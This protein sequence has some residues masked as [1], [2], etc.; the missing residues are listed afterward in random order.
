MEFT[1]FR[2]E[3]IRSPQVQCTCDLSSV[4]RPTVATTPK[5]RIEIIKDLKKKAQLRRA[6]ARG[7]VPKGTV[8]QTVPAPQQ[9]AQL[10][11]KCSCEAS[12]PRKMITRQIPIVTKK[13]PIKTPY[14]LA[15]FCKNN[16]I[17]VSN[18]D[19]ANMGQIKDPTRLRPGV[20]PTKTFEIVIEPDKISQKQIEENYQAVQSY[21]PT[22]VNNGYFCSTCDPFL[23]LVCKLF[24][25][26][27]THKY[28]T[29]TMYYIN[30]QTTEGIFSNNSLKIQ[31]TKTLTFTS[32]RGHFDVLA[33]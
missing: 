3:T 26:S 32:N 24:N 28:L 4:V 21:S 23:F 9:N 18:V 27:I 1:T 16:N 2:T 12:K 7:D 11:K 33:C 25:V 20:T 31:K 14:D 19:W 5:T 8:Y 30:N 15:E 13:G 22:E 6:I 29:N 17:R 10:P